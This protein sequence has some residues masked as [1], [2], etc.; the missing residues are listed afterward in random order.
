MNLTTLTIRETMA[1]SEDEGVPHAQFEDES[2]VH[3]RTPTPQRQRHLSAQLQDEQEEA[4]TSRGFEIESI[5]RHLTCP[6][7][8]NLFTDPRSL[9]CLDSFC[10]GCLNQNIREKL[11]EWRKLAVEREEERR[12]R[13][14]VEE[15]QDQSDDEQDQSDEEDEH[16]TI[17]T[18]CSPVNTPSIFTVNSLVNDFQYRC[19][20]GCKCDTGINVNEDGTVQ[21]PGF[22]RLNRVII[23]LIRTLE[24]K[25]KVPKGTIICGE[26]QLPDSVA[27]AI[28]NNEECANKPLCGPCL[29]H[30]LRASTTREH[31]IV[32]PSIRV[33]ERDSGARPDPD[34]PDEWKYFAR[35]SWYCHNHPTNPVD[36]YCKDCDEVICRDCS[37]IANGHRRC[38]NVDMAETYCE[39]EYA[40]IFQKIDDVEKLQK[41]FEAGIKNIESITDS[42]HE[43]RDFI[44]TSITDHCENLIQDLQDQRDVLIQQTHEICDLKTRQLAER[45]KMLQRISE[46]FVRS[47]D[48]IR[49]VVVNVPIPVEIMFLKTQLMERLN[50]LITHYTN[51]ERIP[52]D[53]EYI[54]F[55]LNSM[56]NITGAIGIVYSTPC[57]EEFTICNFPRRL[58]AG[59]EYS[60]L[61]ITRDIF[62]TRVRRVWGPEMLP[63]KA[64]ITYM[65]GNNLDEDEDDDNYTLDGQQSLDWFVSPDNDSGIYTIKILPA[66]SG[67]YLISVYSPKPPPINRLYIRGCPKRVY[68]EP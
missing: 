31:R 1:T 15:E 44:I 23:N 56:F 55:Y 2:P 68:V 32:H 11:E 36:R 29:D 34:P 48:F 16:S 24:L 30:H 3:S 65:E 37:D 33:Q 9:P 64:S 18:Q 13:H 4:Q 46:T 62:G 51:Y 59:R 47:L 66:T 41:K 38:P 14:L 28:C 17:P 54:F 5:I 35:R 53:N 50:Y 52:N 10:S 27:I 60:F 25:E 43:R 67:Y 20:L 22:P 61:V 19:P 6:L 49:D 42:L 57:V 40:P 26:C 63:L 21:E 8:G 39:E 7:C 12:R 45:Q 58:R